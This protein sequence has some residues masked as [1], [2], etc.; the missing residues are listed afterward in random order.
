MM[1]LARDAGVR[2]TDAPSKK[3]LWFQF[4]PKPWSMPPAPVAPPHCKQSPSSVGFGEL[5]PPV[6]TFWPASEPKPVSEVSQDHPAIAATATKDHVSKARNIYHTVTHGLCVV[7]VS[8]GRHARRFCT[9]DKKF[10]H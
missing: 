2:A 4:A 8:R 3:P 6:P 5:P 10:P 9:V 1:S 7:V